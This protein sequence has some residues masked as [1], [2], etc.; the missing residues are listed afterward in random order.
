MKT[1]WYKKQLVGWRKKDGETTHHI[2]EA[3][4]QKEIEMLINDGWSVRPHGVHILRS[5]E[6]YKA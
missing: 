2:D 3:Q 4:M 5:V 1:I 6:V